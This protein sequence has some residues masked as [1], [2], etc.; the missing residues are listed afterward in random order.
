MCQ[1]IGVPFAGAQESGT[2]CRAYTDAGTAGW[3]EPRVLR[4]IGE[5]AIE[6]QNAYSD[7]TLAAFDAYAEGHVDFLADFGDFGGEQT[8]RT[9]RI[10]LQLEWARGRGSLQ[11]LVGR[12]N[13]TWAPTRI[14]YHIDHLSLVMENFGRTIEVGE[15]DEVKDVLHPIADGARDFYSYRLVDSMA[16]MVGPHTSQV[17]RVQVRPTCQDDPGVVGTLDLDYASM[18]IARMT[19]SFTPAAYVDPTVSS[20]SLELTNG[21]VE[22][23]FWLPVRQ[24]VEVRRQIRWMD[25]PFSTTIRS[26]FEILDY[27]LDPDPHYRVRGGH[28]VAALP[29]EELERYAGWQREEMRITG[30]FAPEDSARFEKVRRQAVAIAAG[31][32]LGGNSRLRFF[33]PDLSS[34]IR[35]RRA[36][37]LLLGAG[38]SWRAAGQTTLYGWAGYAF[39][40]EKPEAAFELRQGVGQTTLRLSGYLERHT[41]VGPFAAASGI[42]STFGAALWGDDYVDPYFRDGVSLSASSPIGSLTATVTA[43]WEEQRSAEL[44]S[45]TI[46]SAEPRPVRSITDGTD[47]HLDVELGRHFGSALA[48]VW[49]VSFNSQLASGGDFGYTRWA[50]S[51]DATPPDPDAVWQWEAAGA[52]ALATGTLPEQRLILLG[53]RSTVPGYGFRPWG[54]DQAVYALAA[55]SREI[56]A[57]WM[58]GRILGSLGW[59]EITIVSRE[60]AE[61]FGVTRSGGLRPSVGAGLAMFWDV[62]R[63][64]VAR[65]LDDGQWEWILS[66][67]PAW[68]APL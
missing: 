24:N 31:R 40:R 36:E 42:V 1:W 23:R 56:L 5:A 59:T 64:D 6:R 51:F 3:D 9:D 44:V 16:V 14:H 63:L 12:R 57:P 49:S 68:R 39:G 45:G 11:T 35:Y 65:G 26:S 8:V 50:L 29:Q 47:P 2:E 41:D 38:A 28:R 46:G 18:A 58:R 15:G 37:G 22:R 33:L 32:Y 52:V 4:M 17:Y 55:I 7:S 53:G 60:A 48:A 27:N 10:A 43:V 67:N 25:L 19:A 62:I 13:V 34:G 20:V 61:R 30:D 66:V 21:W 54:G